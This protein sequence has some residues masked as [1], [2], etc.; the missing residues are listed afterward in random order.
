MFVSSLLEVS[1]LLVVV[2]SVGFHGISTTLEDVLAAAVVVIA[3]VE[4]QLLEDVEVLVEGTS[5][6]DGQLA[7]LESQRG[8]KR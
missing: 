3:P 1:I 7:V 8:W 2:D 5:S 4:V 6:E